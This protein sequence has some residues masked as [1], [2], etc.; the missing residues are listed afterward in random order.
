MSSTPRARRPAHRGG[1]HDPILGLWAGAAPVLILGL[2]LL[3]AFL[4]AINGALT[5]IYPG[6]VFPTEV[7]GVGTGF[8]AAISRLGAATGTFLMPVGIAALLWGAIRPEEREMS[9]CFK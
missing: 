7:R 2:F 8:A 5:S 1:C 9:S 3:F 6:E 4:N